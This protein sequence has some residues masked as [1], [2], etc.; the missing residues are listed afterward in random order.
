V[1]SR[2]PPGSAL[3]GALAEH[4]LQATWTDSGPSAVCEAV[5]G[6]LAACFIGVGR[7]GEWEVDF[8][9]CLNRVDPGLPLI[10]IS[11][12]DSIELQR[13]LRRHRVFYYLL[14]PLDAEELRAVIDAAVRGRDGR[15]IFPQRL[16]LSPHRR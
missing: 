5:S 4:G 13:R 1:F 7:H 9:P 15:P 2:R 6:D 12:R 3:G 10:V 8:L 11:D 14:E 16:D